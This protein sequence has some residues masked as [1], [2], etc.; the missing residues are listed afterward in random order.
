VVNIPYQKAVFEAGELKGDIAIHDV[1]YGN[2][3][4]NIGTDLF[5]ELHVKFGD[6]LHVVIFHNHTKVYEGD[7]PYCQ[8]FAIVPVGKPLVY[9]NSL[10]QVSFALNQGS[11]AKAFKIG[12]GSEW[13]VEVSKK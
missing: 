8:T 4:T 5:N 9:L 11:F 13:S 3:W 7:M 2:V 6:V 1:Q 12:S 10:M